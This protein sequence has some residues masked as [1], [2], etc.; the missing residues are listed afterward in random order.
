MSGPF[1][2]GLA[3]C[4][5]LALL[6][7]AT[8]WWRTRQETQ[9]LTVA[10]NYLR[11]TLGKMTVAIAEKD[12]EI[13]RLTQSPCA[14]QKKSRAGLGSAPRGTERPLAASVMMSAN[15]TK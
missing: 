7:S 4:L 5:G 13:D 15:R 10:N 14:G 9:A 8:T 12:R 3:M 2:K 1:Y 11:E 6:F